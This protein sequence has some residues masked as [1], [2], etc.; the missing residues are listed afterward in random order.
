MARR[1]HR[2]YL[3]VPDRTWIATVTFQDGTRITAALHGPN[4]SEAELRYAREHASTNGGVRAI[5]VHQE[6]WIR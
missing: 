1:N 4:C 6:S 2:A 3:H 5:I